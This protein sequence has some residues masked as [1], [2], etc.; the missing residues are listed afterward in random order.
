MESLLLGS[1]VGA[2]YTLNKD[3]KNNR[4]NNVSNDLFTDPSQNSIYSSNYLENVNNIEKGF[5]RD[6]FEKSKD[7]LNT[8][9]IP[10]VLIIK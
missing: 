2:G 3:G 5:A 9:V 8:N 4:Q 6:N 10:L 7:A 1:V